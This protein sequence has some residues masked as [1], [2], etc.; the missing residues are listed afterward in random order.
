MMWGALIAWYLFLAGL[1]AGA[2]LTSVAVERW[3]PERTKFVVASRCLAFVA[4]CVGLVLL[5]IDA[6]GSHHNPLALFY[7]LCGMKS[8]V[9]SWGVVILAVSAA[10]Y[11]VLAAAGLFAH[12][13]CAF[14]SFVEKVRKPLTVLGV[15]FSIGLAAYTGLL[16]GVIKTAPLW[17]NALLPVLFTVSAL[18]AGAAG[19]YVVASLVAQQEIAGMHRL[20]HAHRLVLLVE[21][22]LLAIMLFNVNT[23]NPAGAASVS[24]LICGAYAPLFW[25]GLILIGLIV[26]MV[27]ETIELA[28]QKAQQALIQ[29]LGVELCVLVGGFLLRY[30]II[31]AAVPLDFTNM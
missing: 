28:S 21:L 25:V 5:I 8:S 27:V 24:S 29:V 12:R 1:A 11:L 22:V 3:Y 18:S 30:L 15:I 7:L 17:N 31:K 10:L 13:G 16:I 14:C 6:P 9:M 2:F 4:I 23:T 26:P 20:T 19:S